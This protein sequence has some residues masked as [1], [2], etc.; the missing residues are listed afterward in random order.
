MVSFD[1]VNKGIKIIE[2]SWTTPRYLPYWYQ[3]TTSCRLL[4]DQE[5][6][7]L[8]E[9]EVDSSRTASYAKDLLPGSVCLIKLIAVYNPA[10]NDPGIM[11]FVSTL[12][13]SKCR[14][15]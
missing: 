13:T 12:Y 15:R 7:Y 8:T 10:S 5:S 9:V 14:N 3:Q 11:L 2:V 1:N 4:C 6:Y